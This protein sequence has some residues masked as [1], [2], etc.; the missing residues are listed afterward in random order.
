MPTMFWS[1]LKKGQIWP[2]VEQFHFQFFHIEQ[3]VCQPSF[4]KRMDKLHARWK[5]LCFKR[6]DKLHARRKKRVVEMLSKKA[7]RPKWCER[8]E[9]YAMTILLEVDVDP[10]WRIYNFNK[11]SKFD[12]KQDLCWIHVEIS[13]VTKTMV[14]KLPDTSPRRVEERF[15]IIGEV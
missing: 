11:R 6:M 7:L 1:M 14:K 5:N 2:R 9:I 4:V 13:L 10:A 8:E 15:K 3:V 12:C